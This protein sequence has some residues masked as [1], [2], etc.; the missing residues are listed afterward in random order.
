MHGWSIIASAWRS[1]SNRAITCLLS[2][3]G[4]MIFRA[5]RRRTGWSWSAM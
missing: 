5:T 1:A 2:I 4:L 3:P